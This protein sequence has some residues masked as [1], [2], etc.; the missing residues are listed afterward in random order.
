MDKDSIIFLNG[1]KIDTTRYENFKGSPYYFKD[2]VKATI[3]SNT[4]SL[5]EDLDVNF[6]G[7]SQ[8]FE[9]RRGDEFIE[10]DKKWYV[11]IDIDPEKNKDILDSKDGEKI[12]FQRG[13]HAKYLTRFGNIL[14]NDQSIILIK[15]YLVSLSEKTINDVG[16]ILEFKRF[17]PKTY[18]YLIV[19]GEAKLLKTN[20]KGIIK[21]L[22]YKNELETFFKA[23]KI[24]FSQDE[25]L[26]KLAA[27]Y[28][29]LHNP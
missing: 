19:D 3:V 18:Y 8:E 5:F 12:I 21:A 2:F 9:V 4:F 24:K 20:K 13:F 6:N 28:A 1:R 27:F 25:D 10:L 15:D 26:K 11:R 23:E 14:Y 22:G 17:D 16:K 29:T 7:Y